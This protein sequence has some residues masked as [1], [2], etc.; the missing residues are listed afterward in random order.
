MIALQEAPL[1]ERTMTVDFTA[2][3]FYAYGYRSR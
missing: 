1:A 2:N 3:V